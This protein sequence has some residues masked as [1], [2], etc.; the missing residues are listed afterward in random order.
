M[1]LQ[2]PGQSSSVLN[3]L[4]RSV[5]S[6]HGYSVSKETSELDYGKDELG[7]LNQSVQRKTK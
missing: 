1:K 2:M 5:P 6:P 4:G 7:P 3:S